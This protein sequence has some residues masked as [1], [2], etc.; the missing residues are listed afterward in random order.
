MIHSDSD[1]ATVAYLRIKDATLQ[2]KSIAEPLVFHVPEVLDEAFAVVR[3]RVT[4]IEVQEE[5]PVK[6][7]QSQLIQ[8]S[9]HAESNDTR[10]RKLDS[11]VAV[12]NVHSAMD[13]E[14]GK[15]IEEEVTQCFAVL[16]GAYSD[17]GFIVVG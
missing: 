11:W 5:S 6:Y 3:D 13:G 10:S 7:G 8:P 12:S 4:S 15:T 9:S 16:Q 2:P 17:S 1:F 14:S